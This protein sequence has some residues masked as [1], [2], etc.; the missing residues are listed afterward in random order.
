MYAYEAWHTRSKPALLKRM[1]RFGLAAAT[2]LLVYLSGLAFFTHE[3]P[4]RP[5]R[6]RFAIGFTYTT[7]GEV[8]LE[9]SFLGDLNHAIKGTGF[10]TTR[11]WTAGSIRTVEVGLLT[12]W[13]GFFACV[14]VYVGA[15]VA[16]KR[17]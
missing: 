15:F 13:I 4:E 10:D 14:T 9:K 12:T 3:H 5:E 17:R 6:G 1:R 8:L 7:H 11:I 16:R 2:L